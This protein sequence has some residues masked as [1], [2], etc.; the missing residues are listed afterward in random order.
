MKI[1]VIVPVYN[2]EK[3]INRCI[4]SILA[5][6]YSD[7]ELILIDDG[8]TD[9]S[10]SILY[11]YKYQDSRIK[12]IHQENSGPGCARNIGISHASGDYIVFVDSDD[13]I[14]KEYFYLLSQ[15]NEDV[16]YIDVNQIDENFHLI[17]TE[18]LSSFKKLSKDAFLR[19]QMTGKI[20][21]GGVRKAVKRELLLDNNI[22]F[23]NHKIGEEAIYSFLILLNAETFSFLDST[24]YE[25]I[26]RKGSQSALPIDNPWGEVF[27]SLRK[28]IIKMNMYQRYANTLNACETVA[29]L[30]SLDKM[31]LKYNYH[32]YKELAK[33]TFVNW[34]NNI[35]K[36]F[37]IDFHSLNKKAI[38]LYPFLRS[39]WYMP[40]YFIS[41]MRKKIK[42]FLS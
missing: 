17:K 26:N 32:I 1:S 39:G 18:H 7:W 20:N 6:T 9:S 21:W 19:Q 13:R 23:S 5:Q 36:N 38:I 11:K 33:K 15:K 31:A 12:V 37:K 10:L 41:H 42:Q 14:N 25:Y 28:E 30:I 3:F 8:S 27:S 16:V 29:A 22:C 35:D 24:V 40:V 2:S 4:D 34:Q